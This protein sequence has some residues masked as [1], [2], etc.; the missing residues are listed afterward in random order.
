MDD[1]G[2]VMSLLAS[3]DVASS[4]ASY[5]FHPL[6]FESEISGFSPSLFRNA[7]MRLGCLFS[8]TWSLIVLPKILHK[9]RKDADY[10]LA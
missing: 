1:V 10:L 8:E 4:A 2:H 6:A 7:L 3:C 5:T 9:T